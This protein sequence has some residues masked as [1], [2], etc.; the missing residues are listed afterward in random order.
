MKLVNHRRN[1]FKARILRRYYQFQDLFQVLQT[2]KAD[3]EQ[4][5]KHGNIFKDVHEAIIN[6]ADFEKVQ[7][8]CGKVRKRKTNNGEKSLFFGLVVC[9][10]CGSNLWFHFNQKNHEITYFNC[11]NYKGNRGTCESTHRIPPDESTI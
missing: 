1:S 9:A 3:S 4:R 6:R 8:K 10:D 2:Q 5:R 11:S 7:E